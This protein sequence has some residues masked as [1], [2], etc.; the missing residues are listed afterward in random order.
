MVVICVSFLLSMNTA[1]ADGSRALYGISKDGLTVKQLGKLNRYNVPGT[2]M[3]LDMGINILFVLFIGN[4]FGI[5]A[6]SNIG[7]VLAN[8]FAIGAFILLRRDRP[9]WPRPVRL[10]DYWVPIAAVFFVAFAVFS[11]VGIGWFQSGGG[12]LRQGGADQDHRLRCTGDLAGALRLPSGR[13]GRREGALARGDAD[14]AR[15]GALRES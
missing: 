11:I 3:T 1:T 12:R 14:H 9:N 8:M 5:L 13:A 7:Y 6:A 2:A 4:I 15:R 10:P